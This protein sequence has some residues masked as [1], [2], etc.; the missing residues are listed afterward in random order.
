MPSLFVWLHRRRVAA[1]LCRCRR[2]TR[3][4]PRVHPVSLL[5]FATLIAPGF[6]PVHT[7][8]PSDFLG[9]H[10]ADL[11]MAS[12]GC[13]GTDG[14]AGVLPIHAEDGSRLRQ[15]L[16]QIAIYPAHIA[17]NWHAGTVAT[18]HHR[19]A[20]H[21]DP[22][23]RPDRRPVHTA[24]PGLFC[25]GDGIP[26]SRRVYFHALICLGGLGEVYQPPRSASMRQTWPRRSQAAA[27]VRL[28]VEKPRRVWASAALRGPTR[29]LDRRRRAHRR[30]DCGTRRALHRQIRHQKRR[31]FRLGRPAHHSGNLAPS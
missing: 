12:P 14:G 18:V 23:R 3:G 15:L 5:V 26:T 11:G 29:H 25:H 17:F 19:S 2:W 24:L 30:V 4:H 16:C 31:R 13:A 1:A 20:P 22:D 28:T 6:G 21:L 8:P 9:R 27:N 7:T 10:D